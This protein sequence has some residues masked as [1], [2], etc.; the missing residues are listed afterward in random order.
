[1]ASLA[2]S[3]GGLTISARL[4]DDYF[5]Y[6]PLLWPVVSLDAKLRPNTLVGVIADSY[7]GVPL[8]GAVVKAGETISA[9]TG[10]DGR[11]ALAAVPE[12]FVLTIAAPD[13]EPISQNLKRTTSLD[14][15][16]RPNVLTG[17]ITDSYT[18][19]P[20]VGATVQAGDATAA[21]GADGHYRLERVPEKATMK[22]SADGYAALTQP[23]PW[24]AAE[25]RRGLLG[26]DTMLLEY[27]LGETRSFLWAVTR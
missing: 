15:T 4:R 2:V 11:Y 17:A 27:R 5:S 10:A 21:T 18:G 7:T 3:P 13:H 24:K 9:T 16:L 19:K 1:M 25:I 8:A 26:P 12:S 14:S 22:I 20:L 23:Q 6:E